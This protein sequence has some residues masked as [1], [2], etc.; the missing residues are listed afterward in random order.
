MG[1][2]ASLFR[3]VHMSHYS[4]EIS[5]ELQAP[6]DKVFQALTDWSIR[7]QWRKGITIQWD[8]PPQAHVGQK[9]SFQVRDGLLPYSFSF[10][11]TGVEVTRILYFEYE[12]GSLKGR[13]AVEVVPQEGGTKVVFHWM[14]VE[15]VG[16][17]PKLLFS[18][19][20]GERAHRANTLKTFELLKGYLE[21]GPVPSR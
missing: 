15:P 20:W 14:K 6:N 19:G 11:V 18:W 10:W 4:S 17:L 8:G 2:E 9:V 13:A 1:R 7:S 21:S 3:R 5:I 12:G 16:F